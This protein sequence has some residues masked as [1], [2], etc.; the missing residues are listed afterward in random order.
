ME[1]LYNGGIATAESIKERANISYWLVGAMVIATFFITKVMILGSFLPCGIALITVLLE[2]DRVYLYL[3]P[4]MIIAYTTYV[5]GD[6]VAANYI[7]GD[8]AATLICA[9]VFSLIGKR[10]L[11]LVAYVSIAA[12]IMVICNC[13]YYIGS[14]LYYRFDLTMLILEILVIYVTSFIFDA[15]YSLLVEKAEYKGSSE[16]GIT[17]LCIVSTLMFCGLGI[18]GQEGGF[19]NHFTMI[20]SMLLVMVVG[21]RMGI[22]EGITASVA[23][24][25]VLIFAGICPMEIMVPFACGGFVIGYMKNTKRGNASICYMGTVLGFVL[26]PFAQDQ[27]LSPLAPAIA[28]L[29]FM[30]LS[31]KMCEGLDCVIL[32]L[33]KDDSYYDYVGRQIV[34]DTLY[35][36]KESFDKL[37]NIFITPSGGRTVVAH[38]FQGMS[39]VVE[40]MSKGIIRLG[41]YPVEICTEPKFDLKIGNSSYAADGEISGDSKLCR[42]LKDG[43]Y[44]ILISDGMGKGKRASEESNLVVNTISYLLEI[45]YEIETAIKAV[46][47]ILLVKSEEEIFSTLDVGIIEPVNSRMKLYKMGASSTFVKRKNMVENIKKE[48]LPIGIIE[49]IHLDYINVRLKKGEQVIMVSDGITDADRSDNEQKWIVQALENMKTKDPQT[50]CDLIIN[51]AVEKYGVK[52]KDDLTVVSV[53]LI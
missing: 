43:R 47:S 34:V 22:M 9:V 52:E 1:Y 25:L 35:S 30:I 7:W 4:P 3:L 48:N 28:A 51:K 26:C 11:P 39:Q 17:V 18:W 27:L 24:S 8:F 41:R 20:L 44:L 19:S 16:C 23:S 50:V 32:K 15:A 37:S 5:L 21:Y 46:N 45:G 13:A 53:T 49:G 10:K 31:P 38:Q 36:Y 14:G 2:K 40:K 33:V 42:K 29:T 12:L 6:P